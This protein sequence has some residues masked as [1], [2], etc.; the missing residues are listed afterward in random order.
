MA[1]S[2]PFYRTVLRTLKD[3]GLPF[4]IG[5]G[6]ALRYY[7]RIRRVARD[8][9]VMVVREDWPR[10]AR[11]L[12]K[13]GIYTRLPF[14]HWLGKAVNG[15]SYVDIIFSSGNAMVSVQRDWFDLAVRARVIGC[16]V[17]ICPP[18][19]LLWSKAF[20][21]ERERFDG[22]DVLHL[23]LKVGKA[24]DWQR[25]CERF[26]GHE[27][28]LLSHLLLFGYVYPTQADLVPPAVIR[29]LMAVSP[30]LRSCDVK[31]C[32][33]PLLSRAQYLVDL[34]R[35][36]FVDARLPPHGPLSRRDNAIW[37]RA[38]KSHWSR[39]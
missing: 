30:G 20:V 7:T 8:L 23:I 21:M 13:A 18:E 2:I 16:D 27:R 24:F 19:E 17:L 11:A 6:Y 1:N 39:R 15:V 37:T 22:A 28:V 29:R 14:P 25:L 35:W 31:L 36:G 32:R 34:E 5:G 26:A 4:L 3:A 12:R 38:I 10:A 9:D 33:G